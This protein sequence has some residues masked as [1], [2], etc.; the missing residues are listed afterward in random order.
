MQLTKLVESCL[1]IALLLCFTGGMSNGDAPA[2]RSVNIEVALPVGATPGEKPYE[3]VWS[4]RKEPSRTQVAFDNLAGWTMSAV[5]DAQVGLCA[6]IEQQLWRTKL[7]KFT[8]GGGTTDTTVEIKPPAPISISGTFDAANIWLYGGNKDQDKPLQISFMLE[9]AAG[10][11]FVMKCNPV[12]ASVW[13]IQHALLSRQELADTKFPVKFKGLVISNC[14]AEGS[15]VAYLESISF[16]SQTRNPKLSKWIR[17]KKPIFPVNNKGLLPTPPAGVKTSVKPVGKGAE[18]ISSGPEGVLHFIVSPED[19]VLNGVTARWNDGTIFQPMAQGRIKQ[20][21]GENQP[22]ESKLTSSVLKSGKLSVK[23]RN[24]KL[25]KPVV[26]QADYSLQGR[27]LVVDVKCKGGTASGLSFGKLSGLKNPRG[28]EVPY[29]MLGDKPGPWIGC[30]QGLFVSVLPDWYNSDFSYVSAAVQQPTEN[31]VGI[32]GGTLYEKLSDGKRNNMRDRVLVTVSPTFAD[33]L[34]NSQNPVSPNR[35]RLAKYAYFNVA[36][37]CPNYWSTLKNYGIDNVIATHFCTLYVRSYLLENWF[38]R[39]RPRPDVTEAQLQK[40]FDHIRSLGYIPGGYLCALSCSPL[41]EYWDES[42]LFTCDDG[43]WAGAWNFTY[44]IDPNLYRDYVELIG[45]KTK[46]LFNPGSVFLDVYT[47]LGLGCTY[48]AGTEGA[49]MARHTVTNIGDAIAEARKYYGS[50]ISEGYY[51]WLYAGLTDM[52]YATNFTTGTAAEKPVLVDFD[53][54]KIHPFEIGTMMG[55]SPSTFLN[56]DEANELVMLDDG[57]GVGSTVFHKYVSASLAYGHGLILGYHYWPTLSRILQYYGLFQGVQS[58]YLTDNATEIRYHNGTD[59][60]TTSQ[61][62]NEGSDAM[63][64]VKVTYSRGLTVYVNYNAQKNWTV[65]AGGR[66][67][68]LPPYGWVIIKPGQILSYSALVNGNRVDYV[69]TPD[70]YYMNTG[71]LTANDGPIELKGAVYIKREGSTWRI[72][73]CGDL[74]KLDG[75]HPTDPAISLWDYRFIDAPANKGCSR[76]VVNVKTLCGRA[77]HVLV[78]SL[79]ESG[80]VISSEVKQ[81]GDGHMEFPALPN[82]KEY[83][84]SAQ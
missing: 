35:D 22:D 10:R 5:G 64:R 15:R 73:P 47:C 39:W 38:I 80:E 31:T 23:W 21:F 50:T 37:W 59:F 13:N 20:D 29:L 68:E 75:T 48:E 19:G 34:P 42:K 40:Y 7:A 72:I 55:W 6:S 79:S 44:N 67:Y 33:T 66:N 9:D 56:A 32:M 30:A 8:Y 84:I 27:T 70:Y 81:V 61:M 25:S 76:I 74:G 45:K 26:W 46:K 43:S 11:E 4:G 57:R 2:S 65:N 49:G 1:I 28:I 77:A 17:P 83:T 24:D 18:F 16:Y 63:G 54:L 53:L 12:T 71:T 36:Q 78:K 58:E 62:L 52:D 60:V 51:R 14:K 3:I 69:K 82:I 41:S